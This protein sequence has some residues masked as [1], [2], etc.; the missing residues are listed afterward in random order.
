MTGGTVDL[1]GRGREMKLEGKK[2]WYTHQVKVEKNKEKENKKAEKS[3][4]GE[5]RWVAKR[6]TGLTT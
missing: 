3:K 1:Q 6:K 5:N 2:G 4:D